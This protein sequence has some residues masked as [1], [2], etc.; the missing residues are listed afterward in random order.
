MTHIENSILIITKQD[1]SVNNL[2]DWSVTRYQ[3][4]NPTT[5]THKFLTIDII[6]FMKTTPNMIVFNELN[7][8]KIYIIYV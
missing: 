3:S 7:L 2:I 8:L 5:H 6:L 4:R 1:L